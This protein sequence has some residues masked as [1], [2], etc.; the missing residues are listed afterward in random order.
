MFSEFDLE[1][2]IIKILW[3]IRLY[4][5]GHERAFLVCDSRVSQRGQSTRTSEERLTN[6]RAWKL[7]Q[8]RLAPPPSIKRAKTESKKDT[9]RFPAETLDPPVGP[10]VT[11]S[12][13]APR[14]T[15]G[16]EWN[17]IFFFSIKQILNFFLL[18][19]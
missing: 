13:P 2:K 19:F 4:I 18:K 6:E 11:P 3:N 16:R 10:R 1:F 15:T 17:L 14:A 8:D 7:I 12:D 9:K 5:G